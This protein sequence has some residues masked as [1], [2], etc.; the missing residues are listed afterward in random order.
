MVKSFQEITSNV[1]MCEN[2]LQDDI[3]SG[4]LSPQYNLLPCHYQL[5]Q[6]EAFRNET[7]HQAK[8]GTRDELETVK[9]FFER[10]DAVVARFDARLWELAEAMLELAREGRRDVI[11]K[12][13]KIVEV[14]C[15]EDE[16]VRFFLLSMANNQTPTPEAHAILS[17]ILLL[18]SGHEAH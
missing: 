3:D 11:V 16:K 9:G 12:L 1:S 15:R 4:L 17:S 7:L 13:L 14:E 2:L 10:L 18:G 5:L 8:K 6:L